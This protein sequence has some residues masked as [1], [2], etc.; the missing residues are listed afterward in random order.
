M[1]VVTSH[2]QIADEPTPLLTQTASVPCHMG[3]FV[4]IT[5]ETEVLLF[6]IAGTRLGIEP[7]RTQPTITDLYIGYHPLP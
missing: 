1:S 2:K 5:G 7:R 3:S 4:L 6:P